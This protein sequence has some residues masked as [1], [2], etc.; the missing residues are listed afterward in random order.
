[1]S[2]TSCTLV[3]LAGFSLLLAL[4]CQEAEDPQFTPVPRMTF[5]PSPDPP[6]IVDGSRPDAGDGGADAGDGGLDGGDGPLDGAAD[7]EP[8]P[9]AAPDMAPAAYVCQN[10]GECVLA[11]ELA[12]CEPCPVAAHVDAVRDERCLAVYIE[13]A[14]LSAYAPAD[15]WAECGDV[16]G[17]ACFDGPAAPVCDPPRQ[18]GRCALFR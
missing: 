17:E 9:D 7:A 6:V 14:T 2:S 15:C 16:V 1:M 13:G 3:A 10:D 5:E 18:A 12:A 11:V 8:E 4:A